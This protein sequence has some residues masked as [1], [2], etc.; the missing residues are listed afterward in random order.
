MPKKKK[1]PKAWLFF[2]GMSMQMAITITGSVF[3]GIWLDKTFTNSSRILFL[4]SWE[5]SSP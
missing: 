5:F 2:S 1:Q 4:P 3:L